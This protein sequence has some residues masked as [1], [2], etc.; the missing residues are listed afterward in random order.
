MK[1]PG[2]QTHW[3]SEQ[4]LVRFKQIRSLLHGLNLV[5]TLLIVELHLSH[6]VRVTSLFACKGI[7]LICL[8]NNYKI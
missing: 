5:Y 8:Q 4:F 2:N 1:G 7:N 6:T 3:A